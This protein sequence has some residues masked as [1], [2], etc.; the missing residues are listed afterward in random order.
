MTAVPAA[1]RPWAV[2]LAAG[3]VALGAATAGGHS[4]ARFYRGEIAVSTSWDGVI[5]LT[6]TVLIREGVTVTVDPGTEVLVQPGVGAEILVSGRFMVRGTPGKPVVFDAAGGCPAGP[7]GG[8]VFSPGSAGIL[9]NARVR[10][11]TGGIA[12]DLANVTRV[13]VSVEPRP[14]VP[15]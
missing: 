13:G 14:E 12:G 11:A 7:W 1:F 2:L 4:N 8:I 3:A 15:R 5:R 6:G 9:E 10:C